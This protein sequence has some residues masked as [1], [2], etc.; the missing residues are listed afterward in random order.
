MRECGERSPED[1]RAVAAHAQLIPEAQRACVPKAATTGKCEPFFYPSRKPGC[2]VGAAT[3]EFC[4]RE[5]L[6]T[7][8]DLE[9]TKPIFT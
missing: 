1:S 4:T 3:N 5:S 9:P 7:P 8:Q 2:P 6:M